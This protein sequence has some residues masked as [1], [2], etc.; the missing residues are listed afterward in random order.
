MPAPDAESPPSLPVP[1]R[2]SRTSEILLAFA[3][4]FPRERVALRDL[5][6][7]L[8]NRSFG[9]LLLVFALPNTAPLGIPGLST[10]TGVPLALVA[11]QMIVGMPRPY[12]PGWLARRSLARASFQRVIEASAPWLRRLERLMRPRWLALTGLAGERALGA[13][14]FVLAVV[15]ALPIPFGNWLPSIGVALI[16]LGLIEKD[17]LL[18]SAGIALGLLSLVLLSGVLW[19]MF[20]AAALAFRHL[21][22]G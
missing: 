17:G 18:A 20:E 6:E 21:F 8:G 11:L 5:G 4:T 3:R 7:P 13:F 16:A 14:C 22:A 12:L 1:L 19:A 15:M 9:L 2:P 10:L